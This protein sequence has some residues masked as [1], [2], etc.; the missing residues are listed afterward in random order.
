[1]VVASS[2]S[3]FHLL[4]LVF[5]MA[6]FYDMEAEDLCPILRGMGNILV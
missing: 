2:T 6:I 3:R 4:R 1:M 5:F